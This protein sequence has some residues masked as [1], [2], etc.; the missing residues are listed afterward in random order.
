MRQEVDFDTLVELSADDL[1]E[2]GILALG[3]R[4][5]LIG[6]ISSL[7]GLGRG[8]YS[9]AD[10][11]QGRYK[12]EESASMGGLN[13]V[14]LAIDMKTERKVAL[15]FI[16]VKEVRERPMARNSGRPAE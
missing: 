8:K 14:K 13:S 12:L 2:M 5:K 1:R 11:Y 4:K 16:A 6:A 15:K 9:T 7:R 10:L 3:P